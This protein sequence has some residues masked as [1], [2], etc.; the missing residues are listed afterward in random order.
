MTE[1]NDLPAE[2][3]E[4]P[5]IIHRRSTLSVGDTV[6]R[7]TEIMRQAGATV[8][9]V[10]DQSGA[11]GAAGLSLRDTKLMIFGNPAAGTAVMQAAPLS[12]MDLP[13]KVLVWE[14]DQSHVWM[15]YLS[16]EWLSERYGLA[17][18]LAR[19]LAAPAGITSRLVDQG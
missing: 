6:D 1:L 17:A 15:T 8:F 11:A 5:G 13:L 16:A 12:A 14:D 7:L 4:V 19:P 9:A 3:T 10:I 18:D 2:T